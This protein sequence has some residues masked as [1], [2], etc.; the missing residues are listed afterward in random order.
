MWAI[1]I[2]VALVAAFEIFL[3]WDSARYYSTIKKDHEN[4]FPTAFKTP[5]KVEDFFK[6][7]LDEFEKEIS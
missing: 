6:S 5:H 4:R 2:P 1:I 7:E 3:L